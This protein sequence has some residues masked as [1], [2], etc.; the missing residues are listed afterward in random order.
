LILGLV[1]E[2]MEAGARQSAVCEMIGLSART[3]ERWREQ[4]LGTDRRTGPRSEPKNKL[5]SRERAHILER[6]NQPEFRDLSPKQIVPI[7]AE[8]GEYI[9]SEPTMYRVLHEAQQMRPREISRSPQKRYAPRELAA[10]GPNQVWSWDI[11]YLLTLVR[12]QYYR[13]YLVLDVWSRKIVASEVF[14]EES[15]EHAA[16]LISLACEQ[17]GVLA[18]QLAL[19]ADNG[20]PMKA[21]TMLAT[22][23]KLGIA[24]SF[25]RPGVSNDNP[26]SESSIRTM[27]YRPNYP[28]RPFASLE[29]ARAWL[30][31]FTRWYN[32]EHRHSAIG[33]V[34]PDERH[35]GR[36]EKILQ[37]R[38]KTYAKARASQP[39]RWSRHCRPWD[40][41]LVV[42]LNPVGAASGS[43]GA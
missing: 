2:A 37:L 21:A 25:S 41:P 38:R 11:T 4:Q 28:D 16:L 1:E 20:G 19:H 34:T 13:A 6:V 36:D 43:V 10:T 17:F 31:E 9:A 8:R 39:Q 33:Y 24:S 14:E 42:T 29:E 23:Q 7:L 12:G 22:L 40:K 26:F 30:R 5:S 35:F 3:L 32:T 18:D 15:A 27:K